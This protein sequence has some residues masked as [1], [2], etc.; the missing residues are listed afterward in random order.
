MSISVTLP[1][2]PIWGNR[3]SGGDITAKQGNI[4]L[5]EFYPGRI[6]F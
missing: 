4:S 6:I 5:G 1:S 2:D 3:N